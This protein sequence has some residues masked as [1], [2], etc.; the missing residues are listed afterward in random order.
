LAYDSCGYENPL[1][2]SYLRQAGKM[3]KD[4]SP[5]PSL[6]LYRLSSLMSAVSNASTTSKAITNML[7]SILDTSS[8]GVGAERKPE[9]ENKVFRSLCLHSGAAA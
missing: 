1:F 9:G 4:A 8:L 5:D 6:L 3:V 7:L 2:F